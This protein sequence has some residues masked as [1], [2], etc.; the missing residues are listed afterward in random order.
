MNDLARHLE[1]TLL[2][3]DATAAEIR[4]LCEEA[5]TH[6]F[7]AVCVNGSRVELARH[8]VDDADVQV[9]A[10]VGFPLGAMDSGVKVHETEAARDAGAQEIDVVLNIGRLKDGEDRYVLRELRDIVEAAEG[11]PVKGII[12]ACLLTEDEKVRACRLIMEA[13]ARFVKT[14]TGFNRGGATVDDVRLLRAT[15]GAGF[16]V[17]AAGGI[18]TWA[19]ATALLAAGADR[20]GTSCGV[21]IV[22]DPAAL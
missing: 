5:R 17:K 2:R 9:V 20:L 21:G 14:S 22:T 11:L 13:E 3:P 18:R 6:R 7:H 16:G 1:H 10:A 8:L 4:R 19:A 12:E 15:V